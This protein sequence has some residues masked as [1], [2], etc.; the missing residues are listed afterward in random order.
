MKS[1]FANIK[2]LFGIILS[3][4]DTNEGYDLYIN[5]KDSNISETAQL[6]KNIEQEQEQN[7]YVSFFTSKV[8]KD[9]KKK[10][11]TINNVKSNSI[12]YGA[13]QTNISNDV[14]SIHQDNEPEKG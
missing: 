2:E 4:D 14:L 13:S 7:R 3:V 1:G 11:K 6:L 8:K 5:S 9:S 10:S 12:K